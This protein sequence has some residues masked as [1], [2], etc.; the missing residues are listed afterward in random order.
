MSGWLNGLNTFRPKYGAIHI[1]R[2][3]HHLPIGNPE[4]E[5]WLLCMEIAL[6]KQPYVDAFKSYLL[7]QFRI[8]AERCRTQ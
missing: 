5:A 2:A 4:M 8:S 1:P 7:R 3:H 6:E